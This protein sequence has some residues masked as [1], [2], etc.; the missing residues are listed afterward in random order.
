[1]IPNG[2]QITV[3]DEGAGFSKA[4]LVHG[5]ERLWRDDTSRSA[6]GHH[7]LGLWFAHQVIRAHSGNIKLGNS[8]T[9]GRVVIN[10]DD[11]STYNK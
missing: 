9:G 5:T 6:D 2:W 7:G 4:A 10:F 1:M 8:D 11:L 3:C